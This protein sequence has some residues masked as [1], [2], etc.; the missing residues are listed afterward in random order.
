MVISETSAAGVRTAG[1]VRRPPALR[2]VLSTLGKFHSFDLARQLHSRKALRAIFT[3]YPR[4][5]LRGEQLPADKIKTFPYIHAAY[6]R[7]APANES[8]RWLWE[9]QDRYWLDHHVSSKITPCD[10][11]CGLSGSGLRTAQVAKKRGARYVCDRGS[12]HIQYQDTILREEYDRQNIRYRGIDPWIIER[13]EAEYELADAVTV[14]SQFALDSFLAHGYPRKK[15]RLVPYG[16]DLSRFE[17]T[18]APVKSGFEVLFVGALSV[19]KGLPYLLSAFERLRH[20]RKHLTLIGGISQELQ[21]YLRRAEGRSDISVLGAIPQARLKEYMSR[22]HVMVLPSVEEGLALVQA[23]AMAC[24]CPLVSTV[25]TG[26]SN[27][28]ADG[29]EGFIVKPRDSEAIAERLQSL[30]DQPDLR[31]DMGAAALRR[32]QAM[33]G[34]AEY[35]EKMYAVFENL[36]CA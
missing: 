24:G 14:P 22:S 12:S 5:K 31:Q 3:G 32:V 23:Q 17:P 1:E 29:V 36:V 30:A 8:L 27:L 7:F 21:P 25:N 19:R 18:A 2:I 28:F 11:F 20:P 26:A 16:V 4:F 10:V 34:W 15:L 6:M 9:R 35:G 33:Q 13:E